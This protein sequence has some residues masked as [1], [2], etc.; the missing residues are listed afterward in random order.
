MGPSRRRG[1]CLRL[2]LITAAWVQLSAFLWPG[3]GT[4]Q[5]WQPSA[6]ATPQAGSFSAPKRQDGGRGAFAGLGA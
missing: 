6:K 2:A 4:A 3:A 5:P 1:I